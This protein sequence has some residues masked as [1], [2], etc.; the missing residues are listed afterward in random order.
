MSLARTLVFILL[1]CL[2]TSIHARVPT[3]FMKY[4]DYETR[5]FIMDF[6]IGNN[7]TFTYS[8]CDQESNLPTKTCVLALESFNGEQGQKFCT[9]KLHAKGRNKI[10]AREYALAQTSKDDVLFLWKVVNTKKQNRYNPDYYARESLKARLVHMSTCEY[11]EVNFMVETRNRPE[12][13]DRKIKSVNVVTYGD[14]SFDIV[15]R[16]KALCGETKKCK[17]MYDPEHRKFIRPNSKKF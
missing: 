17:L 10:V 4:V 3:S 7:I 14:G 8:M 13:Q 6:S 9:V 5:D 16:N 1:S 12:S 15:Y 11:E 2:Q